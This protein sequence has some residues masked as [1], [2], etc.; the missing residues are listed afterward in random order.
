MPLV[1]ARAMM[2]AATPA[3]MPRIEIAVTNPTTA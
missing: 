1:I 2:S 3:A